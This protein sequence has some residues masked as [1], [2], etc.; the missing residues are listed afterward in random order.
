[1]RSLDRDV[2]IGHL[3]ALSKLQPKR[4]KIERVR[5]ICRNSRLWANQLVRLEFNRL[6]TTGTK[7]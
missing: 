7:W 4:T 6:S 2:R 1:M 3:K 5:K